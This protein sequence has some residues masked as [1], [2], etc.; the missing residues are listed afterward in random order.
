M[1]PSLTIIIPCLNEDLAIASVIK[2]YRE[3]LPGADILVIDNGSSDKTS[4]RAREAGARVIHEPR[5]GKA[6]A[7][8][9]A[10]EQVESDL[11]LMTDGDGSYPA[12]G[13]KMLL[14]HYINQPADLITGIRKA[15]IR[16]NAFRP[17]H[18]TGSSAFARVFAL[19][20]GYQP[21]DIFSGLRLMSKRFYKNIPILSRGFGLEIELSIQAV[22]KSMTLAEVVIPFGER[23]KGS[24]S[25]LRTFRDGFHILLVLILLFRD[26]RPLSFFGVIGLIFFAAS[27]LSGYLPVYEFFTTGL[28]GRFPLAILAASLMVLSIVTFQTGLILES[29]LRH[30]RERSQIDLR[31]FK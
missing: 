14:D 30:T 17:M 22:E 7:V 25:K 20:F 13:G 29:S 26:Y 21:G 9:T 2:D 31:H 27:I 28:V 19:V 10:L 23:A 18:Q 16:A 11:V 6:R 1:N 3:A 24:D 15:E 5:S 8:A 4:E 12:E